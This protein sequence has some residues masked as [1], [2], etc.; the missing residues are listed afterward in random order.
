MTV[1]SLVAALFIGSAIGSV[2]GAP[3]AE[4]AAYGELFIIA[5]F[6]TVPL[7]L[8]GSLARRRFV[9]PSSLRRPT[10]NHGCYLS[11][12]VHP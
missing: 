2:L 6:V 12:D 10:A 1:A 5:P 7:T 8:V 11:S 3:L 9:P 4:R